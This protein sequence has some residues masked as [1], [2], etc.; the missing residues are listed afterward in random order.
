MQDA[1]STLSWTNQSLEEHVPP[2]RFLYTLSFTERHRPKIV[3]SRK[4]MLSRPLRRHLAKYRTTALARSGT[5][6]EWGTKEKP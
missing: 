2:S 5:A 1:K 6:V 3:E 4:R